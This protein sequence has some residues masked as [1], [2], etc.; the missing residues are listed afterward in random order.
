MSSTKSTVKTTDNKKGTVKVSGDAAKKLNQSSSSSSSKTTTSTKTNVESKPKSSTT[1]S[2]SSA[3][4]SNAS[5]SSAGKAAKSKKTGKSGSSESS[6]KSGKSRFSGLEKGDAPNN[7]TAYINGTFNVNTA[8]KEL[9]SYITTT[10]GNEELGTNNA[11]YAY[12]AITE[13][14]LLS[15]VRSS[16]QYMKKN[17]KQADMFDVNFENLSRCM[18]ESDAMRKAFKNRVYVVE[19]FDPTSLNYTSGFFESDKVI[20]AY[21]EAR[22]FPN[23]TN[24]VVSNDAINYL[25]YIIRHSLSELTRTA[26]E[27]CAYARKK[28]VSIRSFIY[29]CNIHFDDDLKK[30]LNQ[31]LLE[32]DT[33]FSNAAAEGKEED[34]DSK[35]ETKTK[36]KSSGKKD[37][38]GK[39]DEDEEDK[40]DEEDEEEED[41]EEDDEED[42]EDEDDD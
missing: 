29:A 10:L 33:L 7:A 26:C 8:K 2:K 6:K 9:K 28:N 15:I 41:E 40:E 12:A 39:E 4:T 3:N 38:K 1:T 19:G 42:E 30:S 36:D 25:C 34:V 31:R 24:V 18:K 21:I 27:M 13:V 17:K 16:L 32:I 37:A 5:K 20:K 22:A 35:G 23:T 14:L 11:Q